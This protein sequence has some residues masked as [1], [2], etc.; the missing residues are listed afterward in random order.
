LITAHLDRAVARNFLNAR[1]PDQNIVYED[2]QVFCPFTDDA[3]GEEG[4]GLLEIGKI[5]I[6]PTDS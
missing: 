6:T 3:T 5:V 1:H 2:C 4:S